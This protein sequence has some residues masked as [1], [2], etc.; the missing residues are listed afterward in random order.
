MDVI[1]NI[2]IFIIGIVFGSFYTLAVY[3]IP[4]KEDITHKASYCPKCKHKLGFFDLIPIIS[5]IFLGGKCRYCKEKIRTRYI[6][7]EILSGVLFLAIASLTNFKLNTLTIISIVN[8]SFFLL[9]LTYI[10]LICGIDKEN[11]E[12]NKAL[13]IYGVVI[14][15]IYMVYL[16]IIG[17]A[18]IYR[19][20]IYLVFFI[21]VLFIDTIALKKYAKDNYINN[22]ILMIINMVIFT[23]EYIV[24]CT[25]IITLLSISLYLL[26]NKINLKRKNKPIR[27]IANK[28][29][30]GFYLGS[31]NLLSVLIVLIFNSLV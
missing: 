20:G 10:I 30:I 2:L 21:I 17:Q 28:I 31:S 22:I 12:I 3:R 24:I 18:S 9:Y 8:Y 15:I 7:L 11:R 25:V 23:N 1:F 29:P 6:I 4:K 13:T 26:I 16:C 19:Y 27:D 14:S 5:Y